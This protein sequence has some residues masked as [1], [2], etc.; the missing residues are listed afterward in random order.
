MKRWSAVFRGPLGKIIATV[1]GAGQSDP[2]I[3]RAFHEHW[4]EPKRREARGLLRRGMELGEIR[5]DLDPDTIL[6]LL[7]GP[8]YLR[9]L[10][11]NAPLNSQFV[12]TVFDVMEAGLKPR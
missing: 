4:V 5:S 8:L 3:L 12:D 10:L 9:L 11:Q 6:D 2:E 1:L 7:Y